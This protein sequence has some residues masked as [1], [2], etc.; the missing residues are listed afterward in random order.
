MLLH[1]C[2]QIGTAHKKTAANETRRSTGEERE[3]RMGKE[4]TFVRL[5]LFGREL[6]PAHLSA[7]LPAAPHTHTQMCTCIW[8]VMHT[9]KRQH[10][11]TLISA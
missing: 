8:S 5:R 4:G 3:A 2:H 9:Q 6:L 10:T 1:M 11:N 7:R